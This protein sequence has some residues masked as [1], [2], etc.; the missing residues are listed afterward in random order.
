MKYNNNVIE[1]EHPAVN[2]RIRQ[3]KFVEDIDFVEY[4]LLNLGRNKTLGLIQT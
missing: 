4:V 1:C 3:M 2:L